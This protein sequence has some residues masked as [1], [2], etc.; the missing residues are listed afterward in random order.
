M[1][2]SLFIAICAIVSNSLRTLGRLT[3]E[4]GKR[5][6]RCVTE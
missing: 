5:G 1:S 3:V 6:F 2:Y 4:I